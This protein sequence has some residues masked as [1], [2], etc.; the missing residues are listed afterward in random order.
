M[1]MRPIKTGVPELVEREDC[2]VWAGWGESGGGNCRENK[3]SCGVVR[4][5]SHRVTVELEACGCEELGTWG[6]RTA[7]FRWRRVS[8]QGNR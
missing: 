6:L 4:V 3:V 5:R 8:G 2:G 1:A 7:F